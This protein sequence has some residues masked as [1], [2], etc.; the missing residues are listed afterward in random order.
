MAENEKGV[1]KHKRR[2]PLS[3]GDKLSKNRTFRILPGLDQELTAAAER[4]GRSVSEEIERRLEQSFGLE[5]AA[6]SPETGDLL[7]RIQTCILLIDGSEDGEKRWHNDQGRREQ[8]LGAL[9]EL[10]SPTGIGGLEEESITKDILAGKDITTHEYTGRQY[11]NLVTGKSSLR[12]YLQGI[13]E[14]GDGE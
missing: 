14:K 12:S 7:R 11:A 10:V 2:S 9:S 13:A 6:G 4:S 8:L 3:A 5:H 1:K